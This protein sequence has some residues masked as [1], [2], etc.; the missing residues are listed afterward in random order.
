KSYYSHPAHYHH[1]FITTKKLI[2]S[3]IGCRGRAKLPVHQLT[4]LPLEAEDHHGN[5][6]HGGADGRSSI[7]HR[8]RD[9]APCRGPQV[10]EQP[11]SRPPQRRP[12]PWPS[13]SRQRRERP[14]EGIHQE[15]VHPSLGQE[16]QKGAKPQQVI[17]GPGV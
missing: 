3:S 13:P 16:H 10:S 11:P 14:R 12:W 9:P 8:P 5:S 2:K 4:G 15:A 6:C 7:H 17:E 1:Q